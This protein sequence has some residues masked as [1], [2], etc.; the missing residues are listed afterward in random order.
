MTIKKEYKGVRWRG[1]DSKDSEYQ[2]VREEMRVPDGT[3]IVDSKDS[4]CKYQRVRT[5][6]TV[7][8]VVTMS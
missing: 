3:S 7:K 5:W 6:L 1:V 8:T 2:M 4:E